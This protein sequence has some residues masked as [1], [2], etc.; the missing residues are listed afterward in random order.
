MDGWMDGPEVLFSRS[1]DVCHMDPPVVESDLE[2][3]IA[4][5]VTFN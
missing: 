5:K 2:L 3:I 1:K 4:P